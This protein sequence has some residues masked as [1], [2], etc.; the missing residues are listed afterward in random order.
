MEINNDAF[1]V[2]ITRV[3]KYSPDNVQL[4][5]KFI[6]GHRAGAHRIII[7]TTQNKLNIEP[8]IGQQ[9]EIKKELNYA[10]RQ[11]AVDNDIYINVWRFMEP[12]LKCVMPNSGS[13]FVNF[14]SKDKKL[15][16]GIGQVN[17]QLVWDAFG[18]QV[19]KMLEQDKDAPCEKDKSK[20]NFEA[21]KDIMLRNER[22]ETLY[23][24]FKSLSNLKYASQFVEWDIEEPVQQQ[25][26]RFADN[27][28]VHF[29]KENPYRLFSLGMRFNKVDTI[30]QKHFNV[31]TF[32]ER[33]LTAIV[34]EALRQWADNGHTMAE[35]SDIRSKVSLLL[36]KDQ[37][38]VEK[39]AALGGD[40]IGFTKQEEKYFVSGN[41]IFEKTISKRFFALQKTRRQ[42]MTAHED[43][44]NAVM[45]SDWILEKAQEI[46]VRKA[47]MSSVFALSGG[48]GTG[49]TTTTRIIVDIYRKLGYS[50][51][52]CA[53]SGKAAR[54]LQQSISIQTSTIARLFRTKIEHDQNIVVII[55]EASMVDAYTMWR[56]IMQ[57][58]RHTR[59]LLI[60]DPH[61]LPPI[62]AGFIL[63]DMIKSGAINHVELDVVKRQG[64]TSSVPAYSKSIRDGIIPENLTT[65]DILYEEPQL[66]VIDS[67]I[68]AYEKYEKAML[69]APTNATVRAV[70]ERLQE[71]LNSDGE[72]IDLTDMPVAKGSYTL[73]KNDPVVVTLTR[74]EDDIQ[75]GMLGVIIDINA[76]DDFACIIELEDLDEFGNNRI[77]KVDWDLFE[78]IELA[79]CL[80]LHKLQGS[81][82][83]NVIVLLERG[84]LLDRSWLYTAVTRAEE[85]VHIIGKRSDFEYA[86][87]KPGACDTRKTGLREMLK[88]AC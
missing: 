87:T 44:Y 34:E 82:A 58:P 71:K 48:A 51:Y 50:I 46:A 59:W 60:G 81:Q 11:Q 4:G 40:I 21:L 52:P 28:A 31:A 57:F 12:K 23:A 76:N 63:N 30:A 64:A 55:D 20:T 18:D 77:L 37:Y 43:A 13:G 49:K 45:P 79:Y 75:N 14:I 84:R 39:A 7:L 65:K 83:Q 5:A 73:K 36:G 2:R 32:D 25:L 72:A 41:Y 24:G 88:N 53:L 27:N 3:Y 29:L 85:K 10:V 9:W 16:P 1:L 67:A 26:F 19:F 54:R 56:L 78:Y 69:V 66:N 61:Q 33:R 47:L 6:N 62:N 70:N 42:W 68:C 17:A 22:V 86:V 35:W 80:T 38:L 15:F 74:H 8:R